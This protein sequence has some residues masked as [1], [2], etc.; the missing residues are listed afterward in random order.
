LSG[1]PTKHDLRQLPTQS[2]RP[3]TAKLTELT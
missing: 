1:K 2:R 3:N